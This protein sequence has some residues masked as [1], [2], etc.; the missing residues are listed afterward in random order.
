M[1][2]A[3]YCLP[4]AAALAVYVNTLLNGFVYDDTTTLA[5]LLESTSLRVNLL[6]TRT[7]TYLVHGLDVKLWHS[8]APGFHLTNTLLHAVATLVVTVLAARVTASRRAAL[9]CGLLFAV[10]PAHV[11]AVACFSNRKDI[12]AMIFAGLS[13]LLWM[14]APRRALSYAGS[15][16]FLVFGLY[17]KEVAVLTLPVM[18]LLADVLVPPEG[19]PL[20]RHALRRG[21]RS[22]WPLLVMM[23]LPLVV[24][25]VAVT[26]GTRSF[27]I[28]VL[29]EGALGGYP[30]VLAN[31]ASS[32]PTYARLLVFPLSLSPS[33]PIRPEAS[34]TDPRSLFGIALL[35]AGCLLVWRLVRHAPPAAFGAI[36]LLVM[37]APATNLVPV[38]SHFVAERY[39]Y[40]PSFG[41][42]L[43]LGWALDRA[44]ALPRVR[45]AK[46]LRWSMVGAAGLVLALAAARTV[47]RNAD[48]RT[49]RTLWDS[50][51]ASGHDGFD[52]H[53]GLGMYYF[54][55]GE[56]EQALRHLSRAVQ[57]SP[58]V[59]VAKV[60]RAVGLF[61]VGRRDEA[62]EACR[63]AIAEGGDNVD[64]EIVLAESARLGGRRDEA[65]D[66]Y[67]LAIK[68]GGPNP[69]TQVSLAEVLLQGAR[70]R[71]ADYE[72]A[73][74]LAEA[75]R[76]AT[77]AT[78]PAINLRAGRVTV[79]GLIASGHLAKAGARCAELLARNPDDLD[80]LCLR[81]VIAMQEG[82]RADAA[83]DFR[84][85]LSR[86]PTNVE[87]LLSLARMLASGGTLSETQEAVDLARRA[88]AATAGVSPGVGLDARKTLI[89]CLL[90][91]GRTAEALQ[92]CT[93]VLARVPDDPYCG[94]LLAR[95]RGNVAGG[96]ISPAP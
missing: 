94:A 53:F 15:V 20:P 13:L 32:I 86:D 93:A 87:A 95:A 63:A 23:V 21:L 38:T 16:L 84:R 69:R 90:A 79:A 78:D 39:L 47:S 70:G 72:E 68:Q 85:V 31:I 81:A 6:S 1:R 46:A 9:V 8:W 61:M 80:G 30:A 89:A 48:W 5:R 65:I 19:Q 88:C 29:S 52:S 92:V 82:R 18:L 12:L 4:V 7:L 17:S 57:L 26:R 41:F 67:R 59:P 24:Y 51:I 49:E 10:H 50:A 73:V 37:L 56:Y 60:G 43:L 14:R 33:Y 91:A 35:V 36:W 25:G 62:C 76:V 55:R 3:Q 22:A 40:V 75:A 66:H 74:R 77:E 54:N 34:L 83:A 71:A 28:R 44:L 64:C 58:D 96:A 2:I 27:D 11:E 42:C 45:A